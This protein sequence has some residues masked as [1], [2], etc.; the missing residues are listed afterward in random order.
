MVNSSVLPNQVTM[1]NT[2]SGS[3]IHDSAQMPINMFVTKKGNLFINIYV[4]GYLILTI[5]IGIKCKNRS[6]T[7]ELFNFL[8]A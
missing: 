6:K 2:K 5:G 3:N 7:N 4:S 8:G 1:E